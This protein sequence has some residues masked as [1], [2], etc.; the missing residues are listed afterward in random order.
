MRIGSRM[1]V[2]MVP[3]LSLLGGA[4]CS[5]SD[6]VHRGDG[7]RAA[8][9]AEVAS[10]GLA[11][12]ALENEGIS[13]AVVPELGAKIVS[14]RDRRTGREWLWRNPH[15]PLRP[16]ELD[17][18]YGDYDLSGWDEC[19]PSV[20]N[21]VIPDGPWAGQGTG[22]HGEVWCRPADV[23]IGTDSVVSA[24]RGARFPYELRREITLVDER[25]ARMTYALRVDGDAPLPGLWAAHALFALEPGMRFEFP[26]GTT[27]RIRSD[28]SRLGARDTV[29]AWPVAPGGPEPVDLA[30]VAD[31]HA[32]WH[33]KLFTES[34]PE[35]WARIHAPNGDHLTLE[36]PETPYVGLWINYGGLGGAGQPPHANVGIEPTSS[37]A[38]HPLEARERGLPADFR[39]VTRWTVMV[40]L[41]SGSPF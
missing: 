27:F 2:W 35:P 18:S 19:F 8:V 32:G 39:G 3:G 6:H 28:D 9:R 7:A 23:T 20:G 33:A 12:I 37:P 25:T 16:A 38:E 14:I 5:V 17:A 31:P 10:G 26:S 15:V 40:R 34:L 1:A 21:V 13:V 11:M 29:F 22:D 4:G 36:F 24:I 41:G 30:R